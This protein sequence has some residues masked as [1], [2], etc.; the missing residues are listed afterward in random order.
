MRIY[1]LDVHTENLE[2]TLLLAKFLKADILLHYCFEHYMEILAPDN[3][4]II[5]NLVLK[6]CNEDRYYNKCKKLM[7]DQFTSVL[8]LIFSRIQW[9]FVHLGCRT[10]NI[11]AEKPLIDRS[12]LRNTIFLV[13]KQ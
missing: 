10:K 9:R 13:N 4:I 2:K 6:C 12:L 7:L 8:F 1:S 3:V 11:A 5:C